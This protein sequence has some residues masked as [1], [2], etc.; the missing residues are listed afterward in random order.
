MASD[1]PQK[2]SSQP[3]AMEA[4]LLGGAS[5]KVGGSSYGV[6]SMFEWR[7]DSRDLELDDDSPRHSSRACC[8]SARRRGASQPVSADT[9][10]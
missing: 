7:A 6:G 8:A 9:E 1:A 4:G 2:G 10:A 5:Q 3:H